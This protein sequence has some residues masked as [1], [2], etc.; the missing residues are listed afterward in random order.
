MSRLVEYFAVC[1]V[2]KYL[3]PLVSPS[4]KKNAEAENPFSTPYQSEV[5][6]RFPPTDWPDASIPPELWRSQFCF[7]AGLRLKSEAVLPSFFIFTLTHV[8]GA[9]YYGAALTY[10][11]PLPSEVIANYATDHPQFAHQLKKSLVYAPTCMCL[12]SHFPFFSLYRDYLREF[13]RTFRSSEPQTVPLERM[14][15]NLIIDTPLPPLGHTKLK[16]TVGSQT[17]FCSR[18]AL[19]Q[20]SMADVSHSS[21]PRPDP[22]QFSFKYLFEALGVTNA[23]KLFGAILLESKVL[24]VSSQYT[25]L[26]IVCETLCHLMYPFAWHHIYVPILAC[27]MGDFLQA[28]T[29]FIMGVHSSYYK[30][31]DDLEEVVIV[32]LD[33]GTIDNPKKELQLPA[34]EESVLIDGLKR[35]LSNQMTQLDVAFPLADKNETSRNVDLSIRIL[36]LQLFIS[37]FKDYRKYISYVR[38]YPRKIA[39]FKRES[40]MK[41]NTNGVSFYSQFLETQ[42]FAVF[43]EK[44]QEHVLFDD[45]IRAYRDGRDLYYLSNHKTTVNNLYEVPAPDITGLDQ[46]FDY[47]SYRYPQLNKELFGRDV[48]EE[49]KNGGRLPLV[50]TPQIYLSSPML[51][52]KEQAPGTPSK[53]V[54][55]QKDSV[56]QQFIY[57][58]LSKVFAD[59]PLDDDE[60]NLLNEL[61]KLDSGRFIFAKTLQDIKEKSTR[62]CVSDTVFKVITQ[63]IKKVLEES[64]KKVDFVAPRMLMNLC[65][66]FYRINAGLPEFIHHQVQGLDI[67]NNNHYW[68]AAFFDSIIEQ[69]NNRPMSPHNDREDEDSRGGEE[70]LEASIVFSVLSLLS[71]NMLNLGVGGNEARHFLARMSSLTQLSEDHTGTLLALLKNMERAVRDSDKQNDAL[72]ISRG[73]QGAHTPRRNHFSADY[74]TD[75]LNNS[76]EVDKG[77]SKE[78]YSRLVVATST[79]SNQN[80]P[81]PRHAGKPGMSVDTTV[82][83]EE[84]DRIPVKTLDGHKGGIECTVLNDNFIIS[85]SS[86]GGLNIWNVNTGGLIRSLSGHTDRISSVDFDETYVISGSYDR[87]VRVW[88]FK[89]GTC[90]YRMTGHTDNVTCLQLKGTNVVS[91]SGDHTLRIFDTRMGQYTGCLEGHSGPITCLQFEESLSTVVSGSRDMTVR[92]WDMRTLRCITELTDHTDWIKSVRYDAQHIYSASYDCTLKQ[93][94]AKGNFSCKRTFA[95]H[96]GCINSFVYDDRRLVS[97][98]GDHEVKIWDIKTGQCQNTLRGHKDEVMCVQMMDDVIVTGSNDQT[99]KMW[100]A[101]S[102]KCKRTLSGHTD[103]V[104]TLQFDMNRIISG[105][106]DGLIKVWDVS[107]LRRSVPASLRVTNTHSAPTLPVHTPYVPTSSYVQGSSQTDKNFLSSSTEIITTTATTPTRAKKA[108]ISIFDKIFNND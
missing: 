1:G 77:E 66:S 21:S 10:Y 7:P 74:F 2:D 105:S 90:I 80:S 76:G 40:F 13:Y 36:F 108:A 84:G 31:R 30:P 6:E 15:A 48:E 95:G 33:R 22:I 107:H 29:P 89:E 98:S 68:E 41:E 57:Q 88:D 38:E 19:H 43:L 79:H 32:D 81:T 12:L 94:E 71:S 91:G 47:S 83:T 23:V 70:Q 53:E 102:G 67:W 103:W 56:A 3:K 99:V 59:I 49:I 65:S 44:H 106:W 25:L 26:T 101:T 37:L 69:K 54:V 8:T 45:G 58:C 78:L 24:I 61:F 46:T 18:P 92:V 63:L 27:N 35:L 75:S 62:P 34:E 14:I 39:V 52:Q 55:N 28:P 85:G 93:W 17:Q 51:G 9:R 87:S 86:D 104:Y 73:T 82:V 50:A 20:F 11:E 60:M 4:K 72:G 100:D 97:G 96:K 64:H 16:L 42:A 5:L